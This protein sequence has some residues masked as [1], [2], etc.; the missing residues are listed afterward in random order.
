MKKYSAEDLLL[1]S[2]I[3][4]FAFC[5]RQW[6]L[7]HIEQLWN[8]NVLTVQGAHVHE[9]TDDPFSDE[10]RGDLRIVRSVPVLSLNL[11]LQGIVDVIEF[12]KT[13]LSDLLGV[14]ISG[15]AGRW[16]PRPV[17]YKRG[18][19]KPDA[20]DEVQLCAQAICI[21]EM[22]GVQI[23]TGELYYA[24]IRRRQA[25][26][27]SAELRS[28]AQSL[29]ARMHEC[30]ELG[31]TPSAVP[32]KRCRSCSLKEACQPSI[33]RRRDAVQRYMASFFCEKVTG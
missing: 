3:Q 19:P 14:E 11:G 17:E 27:F 18:K 30:Y 13:Q 9:R 23:S 12:R 26:E 20:C 21:E 33:A 8:E 1:L 15:A 24:Q 29:S 2:G 22:M 4:H 7:I 25:V 16:R 6:A 10:T 31:I 28:L 32:S 5:E